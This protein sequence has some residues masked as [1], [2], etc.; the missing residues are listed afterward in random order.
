MHQAT[1]H[2]ESSDAPQHEH[3]IKNNGE[4]KIKKVLHLSLLHEPNN[5]MH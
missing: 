4:L 2:E 1:V 3:S 5:T